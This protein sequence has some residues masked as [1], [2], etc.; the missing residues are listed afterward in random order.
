MHYARGVTG[1]RGGVLAAAAVL[2]LSA[3]CAAA[4]DVKVEA[5]AGEPF[6]VARM[7]VPLSD[8]VR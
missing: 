7:V 5:A 2:W 3:L 1:R 8:A 4:G 6:G